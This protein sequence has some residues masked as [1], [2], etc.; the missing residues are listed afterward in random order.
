MSGLLELEA[1]L[2]AKLEPLFEPHRYKVIY[3]G[4]GG[5]KS[6]SIARSLI[7]MA[8]ERPLRILCAREF[9]SSIADSVHKLLSDQIND[10]GLADQ[11]T[12]EKATIYHING[13]E[14]RFAGIRTNIGAIKSFEGIDICWVEE[15][16]N[17]SRS[18]WMT[19]IP[20]IRKDGSEIWVSFNPELE[21]DETYQRFV[22]KPPASAIVI[23]IG[24]EDN[25][26]FPDTLRQEAEELK[27]TNIDDYLHVYGGQCRHALEGAVFA[28]ELRDAAKRIVNVPWNSAKPVD[29]FWDLGKRDMCSIWFA[30]VIGFEY[31]ILDFYENCGQILPHYI[32]TLKELPYAYGTHWLPH[33]ADHDLLASER[34]ITQQLRSTFS[35]VRVV[36]RTAKFTQIEA[37]RS[38][39]GQCWFDQEKTSYGVQHL[40]HYQFEVHPE[41]GQRSKE[42]LH[43]EHSH[44]ADAFMVMA[45]SIRTSVNERV[46]VIPEFHNFDSAMGVLG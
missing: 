32:K 28:N 46:P 10:L 19:L 11:F 23:P 41:T 17:V 44:A 1:D 31:R 18:S 27:E 16:A 40:R 15:A 43:D 24:W 38:L 2:P 13:S 8:C 34:T 37:G 42:P 14:F 36:P 26:W 3:G 4:R 20:T 5:A 9:Q 12:I 45:M 6:W 29:T 25:P 39:F 33:D 35:S 21:T 7:I 30:Q 22:I